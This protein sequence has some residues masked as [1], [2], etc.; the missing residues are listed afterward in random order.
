MQRDSHVMLLRVFV[1]GCSMRCV[2]FSARV[3]YLV[4]FSAVFSSAASAATITSVTGGVSLSHGDGFK[5]VSSGA[6]A[7]AG[8]TVMA[9]PSGSAEIVYD[10]GCRQKVDAGTTVVVSA[11]S[12]C[13]SA[14]AP[15]D[16][17]LG[18]AVVGGIAAGIVLTNNDDDNK[19]ASP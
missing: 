13:K 12:P 10:D 17:I 15:T 9:G 14:G 5:R 19:P 11:T 2:K 3:F 18:A 16:Y 6:S 7:H 4:L 1:W 8:D